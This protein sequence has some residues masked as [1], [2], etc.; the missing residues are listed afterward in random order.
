MHHLID[1]R[2]GRPAHTRVAAV[3][4]AGPAAWSSEGLAKSAVVLGPVLGP[5]ILQ[6]HGIRAW[7]Y[8]DD[9]SVITVEP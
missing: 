5:A 6:E 1:P 8:L 3:V 9:R 2:T 4:A 7:L